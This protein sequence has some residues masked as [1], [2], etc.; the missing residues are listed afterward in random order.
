MSRWRSL[1]ALKRGELNRLFGLNRRIFKAYLLK[2]S[3]EQ[4]WNY[5]YAGAM[6]NYLKRWIN[7]LKW[8]RLIP[9]EKLADT[10]LKHLTG[11]LNYCDT[12]VRFGVVEAVNGNIRMLINRG[13]G[14][15]NLRYLLLKAKRIAV[16][17]IEFISFQTV[18]KAA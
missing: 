6:A 1:S 13:R 3:L 16:A 2:E 18:Q 14:Y 8:Q 17:N 7:Q 15:T 9:F 11:I 5:S 4:L 10:L 12:K